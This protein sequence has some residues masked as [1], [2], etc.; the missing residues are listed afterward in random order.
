M[1]L[2]EIV[3]SYL[4]ANGYDGLCEPGSE[5]GCELADLIPCGV[6]ADLCVP[7][8]KH[9]NEGD[10]DYAWTMRTEKPTGGQS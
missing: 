10:E 7:G 9:Q 8:Y 1:N 2:R 4:K 3:E 5:C 6:N